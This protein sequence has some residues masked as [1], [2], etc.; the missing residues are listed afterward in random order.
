[1][2]ELKM[3]SNSK[4]TKITINTNYELTKKFLTKSMKRSN[5]KTTKL[6]INT[7][8]R[9]YKNFCNKKL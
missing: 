5:S 3:S 4:T 6:N 9:L 8:Y 7:N 1:M 2:D